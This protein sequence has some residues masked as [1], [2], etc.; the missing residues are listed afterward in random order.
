MHRVLRH[1]LLYVLQQVAKIC[2]ASSHRNKINSYIYI[3]NRK[4]NARILNVGDCVEM[5]LPNNRDM[6]VSCHV[7]A[8]VK[9][10]DDTSEEGNMIV[11]RYWGNNKKD[12]FGKCSCTGHWKSDLIK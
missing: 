12:G 2:A 4:I 7:L 1:T 11:F 8:I 9:D 3:E 10:P 6:K 5:K